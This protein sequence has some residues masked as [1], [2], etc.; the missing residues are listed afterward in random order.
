MS[1]T[2][3][4]ATNS[5]RKQEN[6]SRNTSIEKNCHTDRS[7][8]KK[9]TNDLN[10]LN[11][12]SD[13]Y[14]DCV[15]VDI[16]INQNQV[17]ANA[18]AETNDQSYDLNEYDLHNLFKPEIT[19]QTFVENVLVH[20]INRVKLKE[21]MAPTI[22]AINR[23]C[24]QGDESEADTIKYLETNGKIKFVRKCVSEGSIEK[25]FHF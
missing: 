7:D 23:E 9:Y 8:V 15:N 12:S 18:I 10:E 3:E 19:S 25:N 2:C 21:E 5:N 22:K 24:S 17:S 6:D 1:T 4:N 14:H 16:N 13:T 20:N 11:I